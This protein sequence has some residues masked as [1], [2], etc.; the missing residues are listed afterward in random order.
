MLE[1]HRVPPFRDRRHAALALAE[2]LRPLGGER[3][4]VLAIP[5]GGIPVAAVVADALGG[6]LDLVLVHKLSS[7]ENPEVAIGSVDESGAIAL[8][9]HG[10][11][12][13]PGDWVRHEAAAQ[14]SRLRARRHALDPEGTPLRVAGRTVIVV[15]DGAATGST[16]AAALRLVRCHAPRRLIAALPV[17]PTETIADLEWLADDVVGLATPPNFLAVAQFY[18]D[19]AE[20]S[21][22]QAELI[23]QARAHPPGPPLAA[24]QAPA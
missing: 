20:V 7:P 11:Y 10:R 22:Q 6:E 5:R 18:D 2:R 13:V 17:A 1:A 9:E 16:M 19:F 4:V 12:G 21:D 3:P 24:A 23:L 14:L 8:N 15:D